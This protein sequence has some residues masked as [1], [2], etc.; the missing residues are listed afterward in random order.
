MLM[1]QVIVCVSLCYKRANPY[2]R[3]QKSSGYSFWIILNWIKMKNFAVS[4]HAINP[5]HGYDFL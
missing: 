2:T 4:L 1:M 5:M 3:S